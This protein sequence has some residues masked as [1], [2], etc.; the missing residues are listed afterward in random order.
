M[1]NITELVRRRRSVRTFDGREVNED[2]LKK[3]AL[4]MENIENPY[5]IPVS[6]KFLD[7]KKHALTCP[8]VSGTDLYVGAKA[9]RMPHMEE[10]F[11]YSFETFVL[12]AQSIG[13]GTVWIGGTMDRS[14]FERAMVL[15]QNEMM[16]CVSPLGYPAGKMSIRENMMRKAIRADSRNP[17]EAIFFDSTFDIPL[18]KEKAGR[19]AEVLEMVRW[20][21][22]AVNKQPWRVLVDKNGVHFYL[23]RTKGFA[24]EAAGDM[25]KI[26]LG[27]ALCHFALAAKEN[28]INICFNMNDPGIAAEAGMEY[29]ASYLLLQ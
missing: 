13:I 1:E 2:D 19:L 4:F 28:A 18:T 11:G 22:S 26:D 20:A 6:F 21:P 24:S 15:E 23:K 12:Y 5:G 3:L 9:P 14:A 8:V 17:F 27:I 7:S 29:I 16:P 10:A 25:Q